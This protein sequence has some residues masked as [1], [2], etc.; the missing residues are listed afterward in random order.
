MTTLNRPDRVT[1]DAYN[2]QSL[3]Y[4]G[5]Y[6]SQFTNRLTTPILNA[7]GIQ[8]L[9]INYVNSVLQLND[10]SQLMFF[11]YASATQAG[12]ATFAN[13]NCIRLHPST[14]VPYAGYTT[15]VR[16]K[17]FTSVPE[18][19]TALNLAAAV[20]GDLSTFNPRFVG[21][22]VTFSYDTTT[23]KISINGNG[24]DYI[25]PAAADDPNVLALLA[26]AT[27]APRMNIITSSNTYA[28]ARIQ[29][30]VP[31]FSMNARLGFCL[32]YNTRGLFWGGS[33]QQGC[34]TS[35]GV[36]SGSSPLLEA[37]ANPILLGAQNIQVYCSIAAGSGMDSLNRKNLAASVPVEVAPLNVGSYTLNS[38]NSPLLSV[39]SEVYEIGIDL[40]DENG[41][42]FLTPLNYN[43]ELSFMILY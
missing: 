29:P 11:Y 34:A 27:L 6:Y 7:K 12:I 35:T 37:D 30:S 21:G 4:A 16:N 8:L 9:N 2:D 41:V 5:P 36:P 26:S 39:P 17:Y 40:R 15:F 22:Q 31:G 14:F 20:G 33:S 19:V 10:T 3:E 32:G 13:L 18:L 24:T 28:T 25:A 42:P 43:V 38:I 23:R 1:L